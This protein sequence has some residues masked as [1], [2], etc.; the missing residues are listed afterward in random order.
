[1]LDPKNAGNISF[2][3]KGSPINVNSGFFEV[4]K[5]GTSDT[6]GKTF[7]C[8]KGTKELEGT[9]FWPASDPFIGEPTN[10]ATGWLE[11]AAPVIPGETITLQFMIWDTGDHVLDST[12]LLDDF[13]W[14]AKGTTAPV[15]DRPK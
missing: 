13:K 15:T 3:S 9:G 4:C 12:V 11:T 2:D 8:A 7:A 10:G 1:M 14:D 6:G 5:P